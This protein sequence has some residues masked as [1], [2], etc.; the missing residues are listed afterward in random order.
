MFEAVDWVA[1]WRI[2]WIVW[3]LVGTPLTTGITF[4]EE[5]KGR[6]DDSIDMAASALLASLVVGLGGCF[7]P[8]YCSIALVVGVFFGLAKLTIYCV[9]KSKTVQQFDVNAGYRDNATQK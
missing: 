6:S 7:W 3:V 8:I 9:N 4:A 1:V 2:G 5:L